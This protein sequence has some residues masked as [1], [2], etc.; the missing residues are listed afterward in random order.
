MAAEKKPTKATPSKK[1]VSKKA[2][3][4]PAKKTAIKKAPVK[5]VAASSTSKKA[6]TRKAPVK[7]TSAKKESVKKAEPK[8]IATPKK[9][10]AVSK[11]KPAKGK[12]QNKTLK[13]DMKNIKSQATDSVRETAD[14]GKARATEAISGIS[15]KIRETAHT[16]DENLGDKYGGFARN[17]ADTIDEFAEK[18][19]TKNVDDIIEDTR[20]FVRKSPALAIG[21]AAAVGFLIT[22]L[23]RAGK[24]DI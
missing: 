2:P 14:K 8:K 20:G 5:K 3:A 7:K 22:R 11:V 17:A 23:I 10:R 13:D 15:D 24:N 1:A 9:T 4:K 6:T 16:I 19:D 21:A 12:A 18:L